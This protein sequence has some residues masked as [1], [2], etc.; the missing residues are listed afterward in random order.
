VRP[1]GEV[2]RKRVDDSLGVPVDP[3]RVKHPLTG[4]ALVTVAPLVVEAGGRV[5]GVDRR[6][7]RPVAVEP[8]VGRCRSHR[9]VCHVDDEPV[10]E[11]RRVDR[12]RVEP[13]NRLEW[14]FCKR[15]VV[16]R[17]PP[18]LV[19]TDGLYHHAP[20][21]ME[22]R[23]PLLPNPRCESLVVG[24]VHVASDPV[25]EPRDVLDVDRIERHDR[26]VDRDEY[27]PVGRAAGVT[28]SCH[29]VTHQYQHR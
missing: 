11:R 27:I 14:P 24:R 17:R 7:D 3:W 29:R 8:E 4:V 16:D 23:E 21:V 13:V 5:A 6:D 12:S 26:V 22:C 2:Q 19:R 10:F 18:T 28:R 20:V 25:R 1:L 9:G 15:D